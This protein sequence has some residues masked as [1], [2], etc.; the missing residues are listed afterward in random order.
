MRNKIQILL[1]LFLIFNISLVKANDQ[2]NFDVTEIEITENGNVI[3]GLKRG[4]ITSTDGLSIESDNFEYNKILNLFFG[5]GNVIAKNNQGLLINSNYFEYNKNSNLIIA[6]GKVVI[7]DNNK[8]IKLFSEKVI[9]EKDKQIIFSEGITKAKVLSKY[10]FKS[11]DVTYN[12]KKGLIKSQNSSSVLDKNRLINMES[13]E[14]SINLETV[15][16]KNI[17]ITDNIEKKFTDKYFFKESIINLKTKKFLS[18][19]TEINIAKDVFDNTKNDPRLYGASSEGNDKKTIINKGVFTSCQK[20]ENC[21]PWS[22]KAEQVTHDKN[23]KE[24]IY[25]NAI[26]KIYDVPV[27]YFPKFFHPDPT[28][29][30]QSGFLKPQFNNSNT[31]GTSF[32]LP[33]FKVLGEN[34]DLTFKPTIYDDDKTSIQNEYRHVTKNSY[35]ETDLGL[36]SGYKSSPNSDK[37]SIGHLFAKYEYNL[38]LPDYDVSELEIN[39]QKVTN[40][41]YLKVFDTD[42]SNVNLKPSRKNRT[43]NEIKYTLSNNNFSFTSGLAAYEGLS[44]SNS[45]RFQYVFPYYNFSKSVNIKE[46]N[47]NFDF[48]S[49]GE[50][51]L[52][53]TNNLKS[54]IVNDVNYNSFD[55][56]SNSGMVNNFNIYLKN[57][58]RSAKNDAVYTKSLQV[59]GK[60]LFELKSTFP[61]RK[62]NEKTIDVLTPK[63]SLR[64]SESGMPNSSSKNRI[65]TT[66]N[67]FNINRLGLSDSLEKGKSLTL[68]IDYKKSKINNVDKYFEFKL[69]KAFRDQFESKIPRISTLDKKSSNLFGKITSNHNKHLSINYTFSAN[70]SLSTFEY[71]S[72]GTNIKFEKLETEFNFI[73]KNG[74][75]GSTNS[76]E[77][78]T[79]LKFNDMNFLTF[80][81]RRNR[82]INLTEYYDLV[83][84]YKND[85]LT[86]GVKYKKSYYADRELKPSEDLFFTISIIP[87]STFEQKIDR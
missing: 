34:K 79:F 16:G 87:L 12:Q 73:E 28:V 3:K 53:N 50:N 61:L 29:K 46:L 56:I 51:T 13:F 40:D 68:G 58:N 60:S 71:N 15:K 67:I 70:D 64:A 45:D 81:T 23:K 17:N 24:M 75:L 54:T 37:K 26:L 49:K 44:G 63:L 20:N 65:I 10:D 18:T 31:L 85:C 9:F 82:R 39:L 72:L 83:Y 52:S 6:K 43:S 86:A 7:Q 57:I 59:D 77:N 30:R 36:V 78:K 2:F 22:I 55:W 21:T 33:Y 32:Y 38:N 74:V 47:G 42:L 41:T 25:D 5:F 48:F 27:A 35:F 66:D 69:A 14:Y 19:D 4:I 62:F 76:L 84:E 1:F 80:Q 8:D 11:K